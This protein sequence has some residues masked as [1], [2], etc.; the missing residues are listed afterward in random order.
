MT[1]PGWIDKRKRIPWRT[2][3]TPEERAEL[4]R[5]EAELAEMDKRRRVLIPARR[6]IQNRA[7]QRYR[8]DNAVKV[9]EPV[10]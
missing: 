1:E 8:Y 6:L 5:V 10:R 4:Q 3:L 2:K 7:V 9:E